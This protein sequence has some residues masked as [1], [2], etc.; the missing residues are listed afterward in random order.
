MDRINTINAR[1]D[2]FGVGKSGFHDNAD[3]PGQDATYVSP[4]WLN[5]LQ[6][7][8]CNLLE[9]NGVALN[10]DSKQQL[11][12]LLTTQTELVALSDAI[13]SNFIRKAQKGVAE[14]VTPLNA[15]SI[16]DS[17]F[18]PNS[19][20]IKAGIV[21]LVND[22]TSGGTDK[23]LT[24]AKGK[25]L[26]DGKLGKT[27]NAE[28]ATKLSTASGNAPSYSARAWVNFNG[29]GTV[30]INGSGNVSSITDNGTGDYTVNFSTAM[31]NTNYAA[32][33]AC[34]S[35]AA[36][37]YERSRTVS[38]IRVGTKIDDQGAP[39]PANFSLIIMV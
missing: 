27:E 18:L 30:K 29:T 39:D 36:F 21:Q 10:A 12:N 7:E 9:L 22:L 26:Q 24:A 20:L 15:Q 5:H 23:A 38:S 35:I 13:E 28:S 37:T 17:S 34:D 31:P 8:L 1:E 11:F 25:A 14:G 33:H 16:V 2:M 6:E 3:L 4:D 19:S 32:T